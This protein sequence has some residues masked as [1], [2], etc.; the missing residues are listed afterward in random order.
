MF[1]FMHQS[2]RVHTT[3]ALEILPTR[4]PLR[5]LLE[6][7]LADTVY[8]CAREPNAR[9]IRA[10]TPQADACDIL[11]VQEHQVRLPLLSGPSV[12][13]AP[14]REAFANPHSRRELWPSLG[15]HRR[16]R[17]VEHVQRQSFVPTEI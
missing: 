14:V 2:P 17:T 12:C 16:E 3:A 15:V 4:F 5:Q 9:V 6:E 1:L 11:G 8:P 13:S 7:P 10:V